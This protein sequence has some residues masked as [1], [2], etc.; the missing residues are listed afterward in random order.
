[1]TAVGVLVGLVLAVPA[2]ELIRA[3][4]F[5]V[6][7]F[8]PLAIAMASGLLVLAAAMASWRP[9]LHATRVD[10]SELLRSE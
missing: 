9:T 2:V 7:P 10:P 6:E 5:G 4:L 3:E 1:V 8:D